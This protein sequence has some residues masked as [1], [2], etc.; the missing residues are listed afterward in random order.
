MIGLWNL[1]EASTLAYLGLY[2]LQHRGQ[3]AAGIVSADGKGLYRHAG[4]GLVADVFRYREVFGRLAGNSAIGHNR[5]S[6]TG[7][8][9]AANVQ[10]LLVEDRTGPIAI[11]H[12]GNLTNYRELRAFLEEEGS[13]FRTSS[14]SELIL[15]LFARSHGKNIEERLVEAIKMVKG[16]YS[17]TVLTRDRLIA[18]RDP[19]GF[20]PLCL[21]KKGKGWVVASESCAFDLLDADYIRDVEPGEMLVISKENLQSLK[22]AESRRKAHCIFEFVYFSRPDSRIFGD[23][24][25]KTRRRLGHHLADGHPVKGAD[26]VIS[27]PDSSNTA[28]V[29]FSNEASLPFELGL[30]RNHYVGRTFIEPEQRMRDFGVKLKFNTVVGVLKDKRVVLVDDSIVR[31]TT[32]KKLVR[33]IRQAGASEVHVR[34]SSPPIHNP[35]YYGMDFPTRAELV[36]STKTVQE[37]TAFIEADTLEYLTPEELLDAVPHDNGQSYCT[38]C[39]TGEYPVPINDVDF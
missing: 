17:L 13:I 22:F 24:V 9:T 4:I 19:R 27:V 20:R 29:G 36:A 33:L 10:P 8:S 25:D 21:G 39:F 32:L 31:G 30:I 14:D 26:Y 6:T 5:Y 3:E 23:N 7:A 11:S 38:A 18:V 2:A 35:C 15:Q 34:I 16:A 28:A 12:N 1:R 37:I